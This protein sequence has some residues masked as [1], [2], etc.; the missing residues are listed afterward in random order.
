MPK[1]PS[2]SSFT[3]ITSRIVTKKRGMCVDLLGL[4]IIYHFQFFIQ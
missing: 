2:V 1:E 3:K 4:K